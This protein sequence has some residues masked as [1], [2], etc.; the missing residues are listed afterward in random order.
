MTIQEFDV[1]DKGEIIHVKFDDDMSYGSFMP[2]ISRTI[3]LKKILK[4]ELDMQVEKFA[5]NL[6]VGAIVEPAELRSPDGFAKLGV[7]AALDIISKISEA[8][9]L[10]NFLGRFLKVSGL[11]VQP[12][13]RRR[14]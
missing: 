11:S 13:I 1:K 2:I 9:P 10:S 4:G 8:Y 3:D 5:L 6:A 14:K 12:N 7:N